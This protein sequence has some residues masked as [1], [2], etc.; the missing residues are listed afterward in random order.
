MKLCTIAIVLSA[1]SSAFPATTDLSG[2]W[3]ARVTGSTLRD[4]QY[5]RVQLQSNGS[6]ISG[7]WNHWKIAGSVTTGGI[8]LALE[9]PNGQPAGKLTGK[10]VGSGAQLQIDGEGSMEAPA[11]GG[12]GGGGERRGAGSRGEVPMSRVAWT[13]ERAAVRSGGPQTHTFEPKEFYTNYSAAIAPV[14]RVFPGDSIRTW[15]VDSGGLDSKL[16]RRSAGGNPQTGPFYINGTLPGDTLVI[17]LNKLRLNRST[18][19]SGQRINARAITPAWQV[20]AK[21]TEGFSSEWTLDESAGVARLASPSEAMKN[22]TV[23][24]K[25]MLGC[26][27]TAPASGQ[28]FR[29]VDLGPFG[30]NMDYNRMNEGATLMLPVSQPGALLFLG[31]GHAAMGDGELTG[32]ALETS[33]D[34]EFTVD[35]IPG[36]STAYPRLTNDEYWMSI[37]VAG[38]VPDALQVATAQMADWIK[39]EYG[40]TD[41]EVALIL[42]TVL[43]YDVGELVDPQITVIARVPRQA[44]AKLRKP[45]ANSVTN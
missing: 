40:V 29:A 2:A 30:G 25:P 20:S 26:I 5:S 12:G 27:G 22:F 16:V 39:T 28:S 44:L 1:A 6:S 38:S 36:T 9:R 14:L 32:G 15:T 11:F 13:L 24:I 34:V 33:L 18:A 8:D 37:G 21:Y 3:I 10:L 45:G 7:T 31:D 4:P 35:I 41:T 43:I 17:H 19:R 42:G 23:P